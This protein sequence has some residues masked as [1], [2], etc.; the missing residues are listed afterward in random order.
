MGAV[1]TTYTF[2]ATDTITSTKMNNIID[3]TVIASDA[4]T[5]TT[6]E[7][8]SGKL[9]IRSAGITSNELSTNAITTTAIT[10]LNVTTGKIADLAVT[11]GKITDL[12][13]T[14]VKI[15]DANVTPAKLSQPSTLA[16]VQNSTSG[17]SIDF[18]AIPSWVKRITVMLS[19]VSTNGTSPVIVQLGDS[20]GIETTGYLGYSFEIKATPVGLA[21]SSGIVLNSPAA[22]STCDGILTIVNLTSNT[23]VANYIGGD[24]VGLVCNMAGVSKALSG[25]LDR[26]RLTTS[27]GVNTFDAGN[28]NIMYE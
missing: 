17:T 27:G 23:W 2:T 20:G 8:A 9:K 10:D 7:V 24:G 25:T 13:V 12:G 14:T 3:Q 4:I 18:T 19:G 5:G 16:I 28:I 21:T 15:A 26:I 1:D 22:N 11:T 6:L